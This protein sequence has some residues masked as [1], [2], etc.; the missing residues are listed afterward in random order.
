MSQQ[1]KL[2]TPTKC[3]RYSASVVTDFHFYSDE[4]G[5]PPHIHVRLPTVSASS[6]WNRCDWRVIVGWRRTRCAN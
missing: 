3:Q 2:A 5:E 6:G 4:R 1:I